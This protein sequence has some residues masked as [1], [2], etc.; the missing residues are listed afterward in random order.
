MALRNDL[1]NTG[2]LYAFDIDPTNVVS[3]IS[4]ASYYD[5][6]GPSS[7][8]P[9]CTPNINGYPVVISFDGW[10]SAPGNS[11]GP[12][13]Y[14]VADNGTSGVLEW[15]LPVP[16]P[17]RA[18]TAYEDDSVHGDCLWYF[19]AGYSWLRKVRLSDGVEV[20]SIN[21]AQMLGRCRRAAVRFR[22][23][24]Y[25]WRTTARAIQ[26]YWS[27]SRYT[28]SGREALIRPPSIPVPAP[29]PGAFCFPK[30]R[31]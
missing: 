26:P 13:L 14:T 19:A 12:T 4:I 23:R 21:M 29:S 11:G 1:A 8:S 27:L 5:F 17:I 6:G 3:P 25:R 10:H 16:N 9:L 24:H 18:N 22:G 30:C 31:G 2:R 7:A 15:S 28:R 20:A